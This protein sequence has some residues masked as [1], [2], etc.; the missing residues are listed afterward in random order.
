M[1]KQYGEIRYAAGYQEGFEAGVTEVEHLSGCCDEVYQRGYASG[2]RKC[3]ADL[4]NVKTMSEKKGYAE[5]ADEGRLKGFEEGYDEAKE[6][7]DPE[8]GYMDVKIQAYDRGFRDGQQGSFNAHKT[9][10][11]R[12]GGHGC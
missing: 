3:E 12:L 8:G 9:H 7:F 11:T 2:V 1:T 5:G 4:D 6:V 10:R